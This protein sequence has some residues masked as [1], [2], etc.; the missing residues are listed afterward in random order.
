[1]KRTLITVDPCLYPK[2]LRPLLKGGRVYDSSCSHEA[3]VMYLEKDEGYY[4]KTAE[5]G[6]LAR[7]AEMTSYFHGKGLAPEIL[8]YATEGD[9]DYL[10]SR[11][12]TGEDATHGVYL[13][14]PKRLCDILATTL[15]ALHETSFDGCPMLDRTAEYLT[16]VENNYRTGKGDPSFL[17]DY[18]CF[19][20]DD[21]Y[22]IVKENA[23]S[24]KRDVLLHGDYC[25][26]N[27]MLD[28]WRFSSFIDVGN[29]GV[30]DRHID[31]FWGVW[32]LWYNLKMA[33]YTRRFL[34]AYGREKVEPL[35]LRTVAMAEIFG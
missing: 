10:L 31:L 29:G 27:V 20:S 13:A 33:A 28:N 32:T 8:L 24:L 19:T 7:E 34:D 30:G 2:A 1:M 14:D 9:K 12:V 5:A 17:R 15:R 22:A 23:P 18:G 16:L 26:P 35:L 4:L 21:A 6:T 25:L 11:R 3:R